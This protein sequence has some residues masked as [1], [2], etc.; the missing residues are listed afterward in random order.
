MRARDSDTATLE[1]ELSDELLR[2]HERCYGKGAGSTRVLIGDDAIVVFLDDLKLQPNEQ[3]LVDAGVPGAVVEQRA[4]F[5]QAIETTYRA[6]VERVTGRRVVS[7]AS[8]TKLDP[9]YAVEIFRL[10]PE[11]PA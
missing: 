2:I 8:A 5:Q 9:N 3:F 11:L 1:R 6:A 10:A 4:R 7:F